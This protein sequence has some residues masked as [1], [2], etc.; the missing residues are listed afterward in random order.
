MVGGT[1]KDPRVQDEEVQRKKQE[2]REAEQAKIKLMTPAARQKYEEKQE[3]IRMRRVMK[4]R[5]IK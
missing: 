2:R 4:K 1:S 5:T 3:A